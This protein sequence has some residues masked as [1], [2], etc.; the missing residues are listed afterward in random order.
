MAALTGLIAFALVLAAVRLVQNKPDRWSILFLAALLIALLGWLPFSFLGVLN[1]ASVWVQNVPV[2]AG[3][4][5]ILFGV[6]LGT[7]V[8]GL[9]VI[10][11]I[12]R[13]YS[14]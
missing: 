6:A 8:M 7:A 4:R 9:R 1:E 3:A 10:T 2:A 14:K 5:G 12:E 13:P 11:G